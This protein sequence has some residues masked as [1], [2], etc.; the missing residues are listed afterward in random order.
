[1]GVLNSVIEE[2]ALA[3]G[4]NLARHSTSLPGACGTSIYVGQTDSGD[5]G[6][7]S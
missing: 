1:M 4:S 3:G 7:G 2:D 6:K 5:L